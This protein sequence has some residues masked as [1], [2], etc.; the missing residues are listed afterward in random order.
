MSNT[1]TVSID[2]KTVEMPVLRGVDGPPVIDIRKLYAEA[3]VFT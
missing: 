2:G 3:D 1:A